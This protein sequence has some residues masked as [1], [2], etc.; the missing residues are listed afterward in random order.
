MKNIKE[1]PLRVDFAG[2]WL[3]VPKF[4]RPK[5]YIVNCAIT[6]KVSLKSWP[7]EKGA[8]LGGS[9]AYAL[10]QAK[11]GVESEISLGVGWQD[12]AI[13]SETGLCVWQSGKTPVLDMKVNPDWLNGKMLIVWTNKGHS[14]PDN[15]NLSRDYDKI[16]KAGLV[17]R[18]AVYQKSLT[19]LAKAVKLS[20][21]VQIEEGMEPLP[22]V[23]NALAKKYL[24]GGH[25]GYAL[26]LFQSKTARDHAGKKTEKSIS[27]EPYI[28]THK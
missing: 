6:P 4:A 9:A 24:G 19:K 1:V 28:Q 25:G 5:G 7:Y 8:G 13:I 20:Y 26:Y 16:V 18:E 11:N 21:E 14:T 15:V 27:I 17:G 3:D 12:P 23:K 2:G 10:L 22:D